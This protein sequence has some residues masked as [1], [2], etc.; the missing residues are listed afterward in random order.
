MLK[1]EAYTFILIIY[2]IMCMIHMGIEDYHD[3]EQR[4]KVFIFRSSNIFIDLT[5]QLIFSAFLFQLSSQNGTGRRRNIFVS[6][7][8]E[9]RYDLLSSFQYIVSVKWW[10]ITDGEFNFWMG[11][12]L[13]RDVGETT[14]LTLGVML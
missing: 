4:R 1:H 13:T 14:V 9:I 7:K 12:Q 6:L 2:Q 10:L 11:N 8:S 5:S 3:E